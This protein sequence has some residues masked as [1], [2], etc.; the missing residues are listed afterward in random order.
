[1]IE[2]INKDLL[3]W[4]K[5]Y[6]G[7]KSMA[8]L[9]DPPYFLSFMS[10]NKWDKDNGI[11]ANINVAK[12]WGESI[13]PHIYP[14]AI[15]VMFSSTRTQ[16]YVA[17]G[18]EKAGFRV[19][20]CMQYIYGT[21]FPKAQSI[22]NGD[23]SWKGYKTFSLK[24]SVEVVLIF[25]APTDGM[26]Y[27][28]LSAKYGTACL[29][30]D[31]GRIPIT[32]DVSWGVQRQGSSNVGMNG[33]G[34]SGF[35]SNHTQDL[36]DKNG[37]FPTNVIFDEDS[38]EMLD[39]LFENQPSRFFYTAKASMK[40][41][42]AG[43]EHFDP[44]HVGNDETSRRNTH[45]AV[46]PIDLCQ[47]IATLLL[48]PKSVKNR[49]ILVPFSGSGSE[50]IGCMLA[51]WDNIIGIEREKEFVDIARSRI[52]WWKNNSNDTKDV[53]EILRKADKPKE[54]VAFSLF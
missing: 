49:S 37:R 36:Y 10:H 25:Q 52:D 20:D 11:E 17:T 29:N 47:Y 46:K 19:V 16:H 21:G 18:M 50:V 7:D 32:D 22:D 8:V 42:E 14:G 41:R 33:L 9:C 12:G 13:L 24:P 1:M 30:A 44:K 40:E 39:Y 34:K 26:T 35:K 27:D 45:S 4:S 48:P 23:D 15:V 54:E 38:A 2:I 31:G 5:E 3:D 53:K 43:L 6:K 51:G 28:E